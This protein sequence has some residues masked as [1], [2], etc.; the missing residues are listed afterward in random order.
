VTQTSRAKHLPTWGVRE[1]KE[2]KTREEGQ[3]NM[4]EKIRS[5]KYPLCRTLNSKRGQGLRKAGRI[6]KKRVWQKVHRQ[7]HLTPRR[8]KFPQH[9]SHFGLREKENTEE[10]KSTQEEQ[11]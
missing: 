5:R 2:S 7:E 10:G 3:K 4:G 8:K 11:K 1:C 6:G 9:G